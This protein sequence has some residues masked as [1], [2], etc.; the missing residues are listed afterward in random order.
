MSLTCHDMAKIIQLIRKD[1]YHGLPDSEEQVIMLDGITH[2]GRSNGVVDHKVR[3]TPSDLRDANVAVYIKDAEVSRNHALIY[4]PQNGTCGV[5]EDLNS[6]NGTF[7]NGRRLD[8]GKK[9]HLTVGDNISLG[10]ILFDYQLV[11]YA[12]A[13]SVFSASGDSQ[14]H[15]LNYALMVGCE[16]GNLH[17]VVNDVKKLRRLFEERGFDGNIHELLNG[18]ATKANIMANLDKFRALTTNDSIFVFY[19]SGHGD[20]F[21]GLGLADGLILPGRI[22]PGKLLE[23][24]SDFRGQ[25]LLILDGCYTGAFAKQNLPSRTAVI[26]T[27]GRAYEGLAQSMNLP[28]SDGAVLGEPNMMGYCTRALYKALKN[29]PGRINV[30]YLVDQIKADSRINVQHQQVV[31]TGLTQIFI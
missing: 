6:L 4:P 28:D 24:L 13:S 29:N 11:E 27:E 1:R 15:G 12:P 21:G 20:Y 31:Y 17:G 10:N 22:G 18:D 30:E 25:K 14:Q 7:L 2:L 19:F 8:A 5:L 9:E 3:D 26:G 23:E 16:G